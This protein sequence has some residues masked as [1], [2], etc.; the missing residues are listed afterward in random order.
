MRY[1]S[2]KKA[3]GFEV[4]TAVVK[5]NFHYYWVSGLCPSSGILP[6]SNECY[7]PSSESLR[8]RILPAGI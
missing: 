3:E 5:K 4:L 1:I 6:S 2:K 7:T 8:R